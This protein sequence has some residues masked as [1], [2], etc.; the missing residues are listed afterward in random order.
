MNV[1][2]CYLGCIYQNLDHETLTALHDMIGKPSTEVYIELFWLDLIMFSDVSRLVSDNKG[3]L[4][5]GSVLEMGFMT[6]QKSWEE[7]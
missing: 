4:E 5:M 3:S 1:S 6:V 2:D 7:R